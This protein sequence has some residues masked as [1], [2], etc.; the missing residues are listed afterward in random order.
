MYGE[1]VACLEHPDPAQRGYRTRCEDAFQRA[2]ALDP[3]F[4][5][6]HYQLAF[7]RF[8]PGSSASE[9]RRHLAAA[10]AARVRG[11]QP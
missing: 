4:A 11:T 9:A 1:G 2:L 5:M 10:V 8:L 7:S 6:A 3:S